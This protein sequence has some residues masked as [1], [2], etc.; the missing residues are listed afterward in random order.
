[1]I[2]YSVACDQAHIF[3]SWFRSSDDYDEQALRGL[4]ECPTCQSTKVTKAVMSPNIARRDRPHG[5]TPKADGA[6]PSLEAADKPQALALLDDGSRHLRAALRDLRTK[7]MEAST[8]VGDQF[9]EQARRMHDGDIPQRPI[10][11]QTTLD[12]ARALW[13]GGVPVMPI[14]T[15]PEDQN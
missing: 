10:R 6:A 7:I 11:G 4:V 8:D 2:K 14:P 1:M 5:A 3:T 15:L 13:E 12:E 9:A